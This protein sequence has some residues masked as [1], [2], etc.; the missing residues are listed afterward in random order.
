[1]YNLPSEKKQSERPKGIQVPRSTVRVQ[2]GPVASVQV[3][4][5]TASFEL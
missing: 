5:G 2:T 1:M 3:K 4:L